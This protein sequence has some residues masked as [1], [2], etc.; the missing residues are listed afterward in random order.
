MLLAVRG[1]NPNPAGSWARWLWRGLKKKVLSLRN[2]Q[3]RRLGPAKNARVLGGL[4]CRDCVLDQ[5]QF[6]PE[7]KNRMKKV[8]EVGT[9]AKSCPIVLIHSS[10]HLL[11]TPSEGFDGEQS[12]N[13][14]SE[15]LNPIS[16][17]IDKMTYFVR[18]QE[19]DSSHQGELN[20]QVVLCHV[21][22]LM[23]GALFFFCRKQTRQR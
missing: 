12:K 23:Y 3:E 22:C 19:F 2:W 16:W 13:K 14:S 7:K 5:K 1:L 20:I 18:S 15:H 21:F 8:L 11:W 4:C 17:K 10:N 6:S 9:D